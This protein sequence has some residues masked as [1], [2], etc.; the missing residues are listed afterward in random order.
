M[1]RMAVHLLRGMDGAAVYAAPAPGLQTGV[2]SLRMDGLECE[3][4]GELLGK[5]GVAVRAGLHCAPLAHRTAGTFETGTIRMSV[6]AFT[7]ESEVRR[8]APHAAGDPAEW[9][10]GGL[11]A[12]L[13]ARCG[14]ELHCAGGR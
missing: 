1:I 6:S 3:L 9:S 11:K 12:E 4:V 8:F 13:Q 2:L 14:L 5:R 7:T 10:T